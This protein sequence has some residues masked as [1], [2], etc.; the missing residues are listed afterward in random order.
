[1]DGT[2]QGTHPE[3]ETQQQGP[4]TYLPVKEASGSAGREKEK[5][6]ERWGCY[7]TRETQRDREVMLTLYIPS[8]SQVGSSWG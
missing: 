4:G 1:M 7:G 6:R 8:C 3:P 5:E 2:R